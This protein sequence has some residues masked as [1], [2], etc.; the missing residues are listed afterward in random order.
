MNNDRRPEN[1]GSVYSSIQIEN[2]FTSC[3]CS[4]FIRYL[5][6][7]IIIIILKRMKEKIKDYT[8]ICILKETWKILEMAITIEA[9]GT[10]PINLHSRL[11]E[12][13]NKR[14]I[15]TSALLWSPR[16]LRRVLK[17]W[18]DLLSFRLHRKVILIIVEKY[19]WMI[20]S[21]KWKWKTKLKK[22]ISQN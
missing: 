2:S 1:C 3:Y 8:K 6:T 22:R 13:V 17:I 4:V 11:E 9:R 10:V 16:I 20:P 7:F 15:Q 21:N 18:E 19:Q 5:G 12:L 14:R